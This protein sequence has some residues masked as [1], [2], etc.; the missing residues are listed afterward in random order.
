MNEGKLRA[1][2]RNVGRP[3][4]EVREFWEERTAI[5][6]LDGGLPLKVAES[7]AYFDVANTLGSR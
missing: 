3:Y 5:R 1:I 7:E 4:E 6:H 2:A